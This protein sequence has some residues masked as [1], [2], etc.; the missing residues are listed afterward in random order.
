MITFTF[1]CF[2]FSVIA[3]DIAITRHNQPSI[4]ITNVSDFGL[5]TILILFSCSSNLFFISGVMIHSHNFPFSK[6]PFF[7]S[8]MFASL[9]NKYIDLYFFFV[10]LQLN[11]YFAQYW[12]LQSKP[13][14]MIDVQTNSITAEFVFAWYQRVEY[15]Q[16]TWTQ[17][18]N[19]NVLNQWTTLNVKFDFAIT[20]TQS[21]QEDWLFGAKWSQVD[22]P[23]IFLPNSSPKTLNCWFGSWTTMQI[24][25]SALSLNTKHLLDLTYTTTQRYWTIDWTSFQK[26]QSVSSNANNSN[27]R[28]TIFADWSTP[29]SKSYMK[30]YSCKIT[31]NW[32]LVRDLYPVY[33]KSDNVI[34]MLDIVNKVFYTNAGSWTFTKWP[35]IN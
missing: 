18:I 24:T 28:M 20:Q 2:A 9:Q 22:S 17:F 23:T 6:I 27:W 14:T 33:R 3:P 31:L 11:F 4:L 12:L 26:T 10:I 30:T 34:W 32:T 35:D 7:W 13:C 21:W 19:T 15:I 25:T 29:Q 5:T 8:F 16:S 1:C